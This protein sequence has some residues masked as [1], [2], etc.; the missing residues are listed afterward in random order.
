MT[1]RESTAPADH[2]RPYGSVLDV[3]AA[4][5]VSAVFQPLTDLHT[6]RLVGYEAL[7]RGPAGT[8]WESPA[9]LFTAAAAAGRVPELDWACRAT[10]FQGATAA[11]LP[12]DVPLFVNVEPVSVGTP[13]PPHLAGRPSR[14]PGCSAA[15]CRS[16]TSCAASGTSS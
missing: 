13:C 9:A 12:D 10:A 4:D 8:R 15:G 16:R 11:D 5:A 1:S 6:R 14:R 3:L 7:A 2:R